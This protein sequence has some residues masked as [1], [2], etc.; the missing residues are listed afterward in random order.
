MR[1]LASSPTA[2]R[3]CSKYLQIKLY[4][5]GIGRRIDS[6]CPLLIR[7]PGLVVCSSTGPGKSVVPGLRG[8]APRGQRE[9]GGGILQLR[10]QF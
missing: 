9:K 8:L 7:M 4:V 1:H 6:L 2:A 3:C 5:Y 10:V